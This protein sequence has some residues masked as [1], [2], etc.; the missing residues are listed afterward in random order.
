MSNARSHRRRASRY[1]HSRTA[2]GPVPSSGPPCQHC[3]AHPLRYTR[4]H[5]DFV[6]AAS[7]YGLKVGPID[8]FVTVLGYWLCERCGEGGVLSSVNAP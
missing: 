2:L 8:P 1:G 3:G 4:S 6:L 7:L 5:A